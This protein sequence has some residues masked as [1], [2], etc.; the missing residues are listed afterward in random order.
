MNNR[1]SPPRRR[2]G[3]KEAALRIFASSWWKLTVPR[4]PLACGLF[5]FAV[6]PIF[7]AA[8]PP[9]AFTA[10]LSQGQVEIKLSAEPARVRMDNDLFVTLRISSPD[11]LKVTLPDLR[12]RFRGF[13]VSDNRI[14]KL[15]K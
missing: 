10:D 13:K 14:G 4:M 9:T 3:A 12:E 11:Y 1:Q 8:K 5:L 6:T 15:F 7:A 2:K